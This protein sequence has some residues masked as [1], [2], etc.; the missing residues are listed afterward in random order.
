M[1]RPIS[2][3]LQSALFILFLLQLPFTS[4]LVQAKPAQQTGCDILQKVFEV[5]KSIHTISLTMLIKERIGTDY[6]QKKTDFKIAYNPYKVYLKQYYPN[7]GME[8]LYVERE[9][10]GKALINRNTRAFSGFKLDP[11][12]NAVRKGNHHSLL[13]A[14]FA[15]FIDV[16]EHL[17]SKYGQE[18]ETMWHYQGIVLYG[19]VTC[20]KITIDIPEFHYVKYTVCDGDN[21]EKLSRKFNICD[22]MIFE[23]NPSVKSFDDLKPGAELLIPS[24]YAKQIVVYI[25]KEKLVPI[26]VKTFDDQG[27]FEEYSYSNIIINPVFKPIEFDSSNP[28]YGFR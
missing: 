9:N 7:V 16:L 14:G 22:Y 20:H 24:E 8:I 23:N 10:N 27:L 13:K 21:L 26:G 2:G 3:Y 25:D 4:G 28:E 18:G 11:L 6:V 12:G 19:G 17:Y 1:N 15:F 5:N